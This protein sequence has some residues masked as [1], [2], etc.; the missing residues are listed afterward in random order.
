MIGRSVR[1]RTRAPLARV[2]SHKGGRVAAIV[3]IFPMT[4][5]ISVLCVV[6]KVTR[7]LV[8]WRL[9]ASI[10]RNRIPRLEY[11]FATPALCRMDGSRHVK[12][13]VLYPEAAVLSQARPSLGREVTS[14]GQALTEITTIMTASHPVLTLRVS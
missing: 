9:V 7:T 14:A 13:Q 6:L 1:L 10:R 2:T 3:H 8:W 12:S 5:D 4:Y 11:W